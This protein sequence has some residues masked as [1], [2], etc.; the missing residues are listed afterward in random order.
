MAVVSRTPRPDGR[1]DLVAVEEG[2]SPAYATLIGGRSL[3]VEAQL[4]CRAGAVWVRHLA[5]HAGAALAGPVTTEFEGSGWRTAS[6]RSTAAR[7]LAA[8]C[9]PNAAGARRAVAARAPPAPPAVFDAAS[10]PARPVA[11]AVVPP[12]AAPA[13]GDAPASGLRPRLPA[14]AP[15]SAAEVVR[16]VAATGAPR[17]AV[18]ASVPATVAL[19]VSAAASAAEAQGLLDRLPARFPDLRALRTRVAPAAVAG[20]RVF[21]ALFLAGDRS[22]AAALCAR[23]AAAGQACF[24][25]PAPLPDAPGE[26]RVT[27]PG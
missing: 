22:T 10:G 23:L 13:S 9:G 16:P 27:R 15:A 19:Q 7:L 11:V 12:P 21:R 2:R 14:S 4:D 5:V 24:L 20:R 8:G 6:P 3:R 17:S 1:V 18:S 25:R 26:T